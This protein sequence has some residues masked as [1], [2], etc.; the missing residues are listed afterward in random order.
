MF[1][2]GLNPSIAFSQTNSQLEI[3]DSST[4]ASKLDSFKLKFSKNKTVIKEYELATYIALSY[5]PELSATR[6][7]FKKAKIKTTLNARPSLGSLLFRSRKDRNYVIRINN[8]VKDSIIDFKN[9]PFNAKVGLLGHEFGHI[10]D[11]KDK[12]IFQVMK[13]LFAYSSKKSKAKFEKEID[14][15][16]IKKGLGW[17]LHA[18]AN[19]VL[20]ESNASTKYKVFKK[21]IYLTPE[22]IKSLLVTKK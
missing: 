17:Q 20:N 4:Y 6:I 18:W 10:S 13:R 22:Q 9:I 5:Y 1:C 3:M 8:T 11:Y 19:Y 16:T 14:L 12:T 21:E 2:K 15:I 7:S